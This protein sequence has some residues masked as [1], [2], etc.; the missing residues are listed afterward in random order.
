MQ[1]WFKLAKKMCK[2]KYYIPMWWIQDKKKK[3]HSPGCYKI[4]D[5]YISYLFII[6]LKIIIYWKYFTY[7]FWYYLKYTQNCLGQRP[8]NTTWYHFQPLN[9]EWF[10]EQFNK[11]WYMLWLNGSIWRSLTSFKIILTIRIIE[12]GTEQYMTNRDKIFL[13]LI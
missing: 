7:Y 12:N 11:I 10:V 5:R 2:Y 9:S 4:S 6:I 3:F 1:D 8:L 13:L